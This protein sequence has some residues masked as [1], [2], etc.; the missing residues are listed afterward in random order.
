[1][2]R[3]IHTAHTHTH[4]APAKLSFVYGERIER[5]RGL[6][7]PPW[8]PL[9]LSCFNS[10][11]SPLWSLLTKCIHMHI[12]GAH[13]IHLCSSPTP[14]TAARVSKYT[15]YIESEI[16]SPLP[17]PLQD[18]LFCVHV[19]KTRAPAIISSDVCMTPSLSLSIFLSECFIHIRHPLANVTCL[20]FE[21]DNWL[22]RILSLSA[23]VMLMRVHSEGALW[24]SEE[25]CLC[26]SQS[27]AA[28]DLLAHWLQGANENCPP[29]FLD[30]L[31]RFVENILD[32]CT[33][34]CESL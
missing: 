3:W 21:M 30:G 7:P 12:I 33:R 26:I 1:M 15:I 28:C 29:N 19:N 23:S 9:K 13:I 11:V 18:Q 8:F 24:W 32:V 14:S 2:P 20:L 16:A 10:L 22:I 17:R 34:R 25:L 4:R 5:A 6:Q 31:W 27:A